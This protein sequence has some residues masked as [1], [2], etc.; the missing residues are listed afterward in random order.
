MI[1][2]FTAFIILLV[3]SGLLWAKGDDPAKKDTA[4][5]KWFEF[6]NITGRLEE[7]FDRLEILENEVDRLK[8]SCEDLRIIQFYPEKLTL[9][10]NEDAVDIDKKIKRNEDAVAQIK[11]ELEGLRSPLKDAIAMLRE[12]IYEDQEPQMLGLLKSESGSRVQRIIEL[13]RELGVLWN[14]QDDVL[15]KLYGMAK[16]NY[17]VEKDS[18]GF[19]AEFFHVLYSNLGLSSDLFLT[20]LN[21]Y[22]DTLINRMDPKFLG[23]IANIELSAAKKRFERG[24]FKVV[25]RDL[26]DLV[27]RY[28][29]KVPLNGVFYYLG[30]I[31]QQF[32]RF[33]EAMDYYSQIS[34]SSSYYIKGLTG[35]LQSLYAQGKYSRIEFLF[36]KTQNELNG[37][38]DLN[39]LFYVVCQAFYE[40]KKDKAI[41]DLSSKAEKEKPF[42]YGILYTLGQS[43]TRQKDYVTAR[44]IFKSISESKGV[45]GSDVQFIQLSRIALAH[46]DY[47]EGKYDKA[48]KQY[49]ELLDVEP[50]FAEALSGIAWCYLNLGNTNK[51]EIALKKLI[52]QAPGDPS[53]CEAMLLLS[54]NTLNKAKK[55]WQFQKEQAANVQKIKRYE[56]RLLDRYRDK[57]IDSVKFKEASLRLKNMLKEN[58][59]SDFMAFSDVSDLYRKAGETVDFLIKSYESGDFISNPSKDMKQEMLNRIRELYLKS[60]IENSLTFRVDYLN[61]REAGGKKRSKILETVIRA[62]MYK[63]QFLIDKKEWQQDVS[64]VLLSNIDNKTQSLKNAQTLMDS[65]RSMEIAGLANTRE[66]LVRDFENDAALNQSA[67][68]EQLLKLKSSPLDDEEEPFVMYYLAELQ[69]KIAQDEYLKADEEYEKNISEYNDKLKIY[70]DKKISEVPQRPKAPE[71]SYKAA[72]DYYQTLLEKYPDSRFADASL[73]GLMF[74]NTEEGNKAAAVRYGERLVGKYPGSEYAPQTYLILGEF[75]FDENKLDMALK[76]YQEILKYPGSKWFDK[77]LYKIGWT[78]Y[79]LSDTKRAISAFFYIINEQD[80]FSENGMDLELMKKSLLTKEAVDYIAISFSEADTTIEEEMIGLKKAKLF[81]KK[82]RNAY[83]SSKILHRLGDVYR[84]Q[85]KFVNALETYKDLKAMYPNYAELPVVAYSSIECYEQKGQFLPAN[86]ARRELF[87]IYNHNSEWAGKVKDPASVHLGDSL[88]EQALLEAASYTYSMALEKKNKDI[89][90]QV[91][92]MYWDYIKTYPEKNKASECHYYIAEIL[93]GSGDYSEAAK[94]YIEVSRKYK[95]SKYRE[96][97]AMNAIVAAQNLLKQEENKKGQPVEK[98]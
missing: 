40:L 75:Y 7:E 96:T 14:A 49:L 64:R 5:I 36:E 93:F 43:Y 84:E 55:E 68:I 19:D 23:E 62:R 47:A 27:R 41:I 18:G 59:Q 30:Q 74:C 60:N 29:N 86:E 4:N 15:K 81:V 35:T 88:A 90:R 11:A 87:R 37:I 73:Y 16:L 52:N 95:T 45:Q 31:N 98:K 24:E 53:G 63:V 8:N 3:F 28:E 39:S 22:K 50:L 42:Y 82:I 9:L 61:R 10:K 33:V 80:D 38:K 17:P 72:K 58:Q 21:A 83:V 13:K 20:K 48:L 69:Y 92:D 76:S 97:A 56:T 34:R 85:L 91:I 94:Q 77:A 67:I 25:E 51:A 12:L 46:L 66:A 2:P 57:E 26:S 32:G 89:Y 6:R 65:A 71:L 78:Y 79:R 1:R 44:D 70:N 54:Q